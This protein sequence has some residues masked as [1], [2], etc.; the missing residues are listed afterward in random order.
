[1]DIMTHKSD[2]PFEFS[3][4]EELL[5]KM[6]KFYTIDGYTPDISIKGDFV[7]VH[8][9]DA[10]YKATRKDF[11]KAMS[12]CNV[13]AFDKAEPIL[14]EIVKKCPLHTDSY[15]VLGQ[16]EMERENYGKAEDYV[17]SALMIDPTNLWAL[18]LM[19]NIYA[20]Q[21]KLDV[22]DIYYR[23]VLTYHPDDILAQNNIAGNYIKEG[24]YDEAIAIFE[25]LIERDETYLNSYYGFALC[26]YRK[27]NL[28]R[29]IEV[30]IDGMKKG[31]IRPQD[32]NV[33]EEIQKLAMTAAHEFV[34][35]FDYTIE[36]G[37]QKKKLSEMTDV[38]LRI[39][40]DKMLNV[41]ARLEYYIS[42]HRKYNRVV[43]NPTRNYHE[44]LLMHEFMHLE[45]NIDA[46]KVSSNKIATSGADE[47][48][49]F[50]KW[51]NPELV[52]IKSKLTLDHLEKFVE[53]LFNGLMLQV[54]NS[55]LDLL[56]EDR[57]YTN[58]PQMRPLQMLSLVEIE[59]GNVESVTQGAKSG[60][61]RKVVS[62]NRIMNVVSAMHLQ[63][64][65][66]FNIAPHYKATPHEMKQA[67]DLYEEY[68]AYREDYK[69][70]EEYDLLEYFAE[71][72][73]LDNFFK[74]VNEMHFHEIALP[75]K[76]TLPEECID[77]NSH[78]EQNAAFVE[79]HKDG[80]DPT[81]T[82]M[83]TMY[84]LGALQYMDGMPHEDIHRIA[85]EIAM[86]GMHGIN[87]ANKGYSIQAIPNREFGGYEFLAFYYVSWALAIPEKLDNLGLPFKSAYESAKSL[88]EKGKKK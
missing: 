4:E 75:A 13:H 84:M 58:Y 50:R 34:R 35:D 46:S 7:H 68:K 30:C 51:I 24:K 63:E 33:R 82:M 32:R 10:V 56:V 3:D 53:Q 48:A 23:R 47:L 28:E 71:T 60:I 54:I 62:A 40:E 86:V 6:Q 12:L 29:A 70:G 57:I 1:M 65:Y 26:Y 73:G 45:M 42:R 19:G 20:H 9:D 79:N 64:L 55:P 43:Y 17:L 49:A 72:L 83:M 69:P 18:V 11:E 38:P 77:P 8:V 27:K 31:I 87:P 21:N 66:G 5:N 88:F 39:E 61:P 78:E 81:E 37:Q 15:R 41:H 22:A 76:D 36:I 74:L 52:K 14:L 80:A 67:E 16:I 2:V 59:L 85:I 44:H 25:K